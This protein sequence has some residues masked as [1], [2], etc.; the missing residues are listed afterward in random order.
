MYNKNKVDKNQPTELIPV[1]NW[2]IPVEDWTKNMSRISLNIVL[3]NAT[4]IVFPSEIL[5]YRQYG[6][7]T[8]KRIK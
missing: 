1:L 6:K 8:N 3:Q 2:R 7:H 4:I 5:K